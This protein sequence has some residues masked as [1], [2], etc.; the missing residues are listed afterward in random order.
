MKFVNYNKPTIMQKIHKVIFTL[1]S[2]HVSMDMP[3]SSGDTKC[4]KYYVIEQLTLHWYAAR[5][6][7]IYYRPALM[8]GG[9]IYTSWSFRYL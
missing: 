2:L 9:R 5:F 6:L 4:Y 1:T 8:H 3:S 7:D